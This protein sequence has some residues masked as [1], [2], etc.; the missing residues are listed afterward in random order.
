MA[1]PELHIS[2]IHRSGVAVNVVINILDDI[3]RRSVELPDFRLS[4]S[5][6]SIKLERKSLCSDR[7]TDVIAIYLRSRFE[8]NVDARF[9]CDARAVFKLFPPQNGTMETIIKYLSKQKF[10]SDC[11][12]H[13]IDNFIEW[14][15]FLENYV[16]KNRACFRFEIYTN[17]LLR[18]SPRDMQEIGTAFHFVMKSVSTGEVTHSDE[19]NLRGIRWK[20]R[21]Q[22][23]NDELAVYLCGAEDDF[24]INWYWKTTVTFKLLSF[25]GESVE[26]TISQIFRWGTVTWGTNLISWSDFMDPTRHYIANDSAIIFCSLVIHAPKPMWEIDPDSNG[27]GFDFNFE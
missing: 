3:E 11:N 16:H 8:D 24:D 27:C 20:I 14:N 1:S 23:Q 5:S 19:F 7:K 22:R 18:T 10:N 12:E 6:W 2:K 13:G 9:S 15:H 17:P 25:Y 26:R 21:A 4:D